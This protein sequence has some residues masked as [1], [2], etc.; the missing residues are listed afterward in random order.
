MIAREAGATRPLL[1]HYFKDAEEVRDVTIKYILLL[2]QKVAVDALAK[3]QTADLMLIAYV[4]SCF[5]WVKNFRVHSL[6]W[7]SFLHRCANQPKLREINTL[8][9][10]VGEERIT[11]LLG[12]GVKEGVFSAS[13][14]KS[15]AKAIQTLITGA[16]ITAATENHEDLKHFADGVG[17]SC[18]ILNML[19]AVAGRERL[20]SM[21]FPRSSVLG[22]IRAIL[23]FTVSPRLSKKIRS[24][25]SSA[26][27][28]RSTI[29]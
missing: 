5:Y 7:L 21:T 4:E 18:F 23:L 25:K 13:S 11:A 22:I 27:I 19:R 10:S 1:R 20:S 17:Q 9:T 8:A 15:P 24:C 3:E 6:V 14:L 29:R 26:L 28:V 16:L 2:F 12:K